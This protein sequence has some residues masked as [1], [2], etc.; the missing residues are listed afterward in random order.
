MLVE[1]LRIFGSGRERSPEQ[2]HAI[3]RG[4]AEL[5]ERDAL[6]AVL[7]RQHLNGSLEALELVVAAARLKP[8]DRPWRE[9]E[10]EAREV[11]SA[12]E[13]LRNQR[14]EPLST[15]DQALLVAVLDGLGDS[16]AV[17]DIG[18][19]LLQ[20]GADG[21]TVEQHKSLLSAL[22]R[23]RLRTGA[24]DDAH[25]HLEEL[26]KVD[27]DQLA[28]DGL[29]MQFAEACL[30][31]GDPARGASVAQRVLGRTPPDAE[32]W[33]D[34]FLLSAR[35]R[36]AARPDTERARVLEELN[37]HA[38]RFTGETIPRELAERYRA[39]LAEVRGEG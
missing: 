35:A 17:V 31:D 10:E 22:V 14:E 25:R 7:E 27:P 34:R 37:R 23:A 33:N 5:R 29:W 36:L 15:G 16:G 38:E 4:L 39:L 26:E 24:L 20:S 11:R 12:L 21:L 28:V 2:W 6:R 13:G 8:A 30:R 32:C 9:L 19:P 1:A 3:G 18:L